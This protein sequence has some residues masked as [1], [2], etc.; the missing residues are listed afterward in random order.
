MNLAGQEGQYVTP[1]SVGVDAGA[2]VE[3]GMLLGFVWV[4]WVE[5][6]GSSEGKE[7]KV[8]E[9]E[10]CRAVG[11]MVKL[12]QFAEMGEMLKLK[13]VVERGVV[14]WAAEVAADWQLVL[15]EECV[16]EKTDED[17]EVEAEVGD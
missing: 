8:V 2:D 1:V 5:T 9:V 4:L 14:Y 3:V 11:E 16:F 15:D 10:V 6:G 13:L 7:G 17:V 12:S